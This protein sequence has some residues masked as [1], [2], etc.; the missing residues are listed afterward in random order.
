MEQRTCIITVWRKCLNMGIQATMIRK[1]RDAFLNLIRSIKFHLN[2][3]LRL[4]KVNLVNWKTYQ[5]L[6]NLILL[7]GK[8]KSKTV[9][10]KT[11]RNHQGNIKHQLNPLRRCWSL[12]FKTH[13]CLINRHS[14]FQ[15]SIRTMWHL[16]T[17]QALC[18]I[19]QS[20][21]TQNKKQT[22]QYNRK[23]QWMKNKCYLISI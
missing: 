11:S 19:N 8:I 7:K 23:A 18:N 3:I 15:P 22:I 12:T 13:I 5:M 6:I 2:K 9:K 21:K 17:I 4:Y 1:D 20:I 16:E 14:N 10:A